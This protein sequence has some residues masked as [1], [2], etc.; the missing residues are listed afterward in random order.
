M[1]LHIELLE[2][3]FD[4]IAPRGAELVAAFYERL[5]VLDPDLGVLFAEVDLERQRGMLL[6]ALVLVRRSLR[7]L[8]KLVPTLVALGA[9]HEQYGVRAE[10]FAP[11][12]KA[13][14]ET[15]SETAGPLWKAEYTPAWVAAYTLISKT[16]LSGYQKNAA[17]EE[18]RA[19]A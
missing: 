12:G 3:S 10:H 5:F 14:L 6:S 19:V 13:L 15:M 4:L 18:S 11:V 2:E 8:D 7:S 17:G 9:R 1:S 16:M